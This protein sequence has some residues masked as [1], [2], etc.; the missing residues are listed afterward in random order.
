MS[1]VM[2]LEKLLLVY[3]C[4]LENVL[5]VE[6]VIKKSIGGFNNLKQESY[7]LHIK[8]LKSCID[9]CEMP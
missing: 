3:I 8:K 4:V 7:F 6:N 2:I 9:K 1:E 5:N